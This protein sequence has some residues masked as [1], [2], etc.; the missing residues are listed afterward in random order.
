VKSEENKSYPGRI[1]SVKI[2]AAVLL[3]MI[4]ASIVFTLIF[5]VFGIKYNI[6]NPLIYFV[7][8]SVISVFSLGG[9]IWYVMKSKD[10]NWDYI[11]GSSVKSTYLYNKIAMLMI[12]LAIVVSELDNLIQRI[13]PMSETYMDI[14][15]GVINNNLFLVFLSLCI[16]APLLEEMLFRGILLRGLLKNLEHWS[17]IFFSAF[18]FAILHMNIWQGIG[19]FFVGVFIGWL[20]FK[21]G[22]IYIAIFA[23]FI[24]NLFVVLAV[25]YTS[26]PGFSDIS[27]T[28]FQP[29]WFTLIGLILLIAAVFLIERE[30]EVN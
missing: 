17:A 2:V 19:A 5:A 8:T 10:L 25:Q 4:V 26:V 11:K 30:S 29:L 9:V 1:E 18:L 12:G 28:G 20:F 14:F 13:I 16:V 6:E 15:E 21:T 23:H 24:N 22:S 3:L 27:E 7:M